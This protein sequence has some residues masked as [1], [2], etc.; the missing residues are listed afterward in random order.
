MVVPDTYVT[1]LTGLHLIPFTQTNP[2]IHTHTRT[3]T[4]TVPVMKIR[5]VI[6]YEISSISNNWVCRDN[7]S[8]VN[9]LLKASKDSI[10]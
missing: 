6:Q 3:C 8:E 9:F 4:H 10:I 7:I 1:K 5:I 2:W